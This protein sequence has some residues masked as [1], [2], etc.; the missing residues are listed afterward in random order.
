MWGIRW[1][2]L[3]RGICS[4]VSRGSAPG[5]AGQ[6]AHGLAWD[7]LAGPA[8]CRTGG[9]AKT[10]AHT[11][12]HRSRPKHGHEPGGWQQENDP[13]CGMLLGARLREAGT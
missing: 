13:D 2:G 7:H 3:G 10:S 11:T 9:R 6:A 4:S 1:R 8:E 5:D 12:P